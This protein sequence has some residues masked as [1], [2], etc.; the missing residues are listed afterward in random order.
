MIT[1]CRSLGSALSSVPDSHER[2]AELSQPPLV[3][4]ELFIARVV[5]MSSQQNVKPLPESVPT[6]MTLKVCESYPLIATDF[7][8]PTYPENADAFACASVESLPISDQ[9]AEENFDA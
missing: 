7:V 9:L 4:F 2:M 5:T 6:P 3:V 8:F 1:L